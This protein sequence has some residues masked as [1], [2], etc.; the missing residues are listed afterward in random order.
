MF[1]VASISRI[2]SSSKYKSGF[3]ET[4]KFLKIILCE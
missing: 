4:G 3:T 1:Y 2:N